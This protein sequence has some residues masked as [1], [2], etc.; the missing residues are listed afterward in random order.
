[1]R[2]SVLEQAAYKQCSQSS[3][4]SSKSMRAHWSVTSQ[5]TASVCWSLSQHC[6]VWLWGS[7]AY[8]EQLFGIKQELLACMKTVFT[9]TELHQHWQ[10]PGPH[11]KEWIHEARRHYPQ[12]W[13][14][15]EPLGT[16]WLIHMTALWKKIRLLSVKDSS[17]SA[18][19]FENIHFMAANFI[20]FSSQ[21]I[22][23]S[24]CV[25][26]RYSSTARQKNSLLRKPIT[27]FWHKRYLNEK[28][29]CAKV[30]PCD[31]DGIWN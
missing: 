26:S 3:F 13:E 19:C 29:R 28:Q 21:N 1:M 11:I 23:S 25:C 9:Q 27:Q 6:L 8:M 14:Q 16:L 15:N 20:F 10:S 5:F 22:T 4:R 17:Q 24:H 30:G 2:L 31:K 7:L 12:K 18:K